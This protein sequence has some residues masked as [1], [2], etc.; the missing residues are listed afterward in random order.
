MVV[1]GRLGAFGE[2]L[3]G[4]TRSDH[5]QTSDEIRRGAAICR[6]LKSTASPQKAE[7]EKDE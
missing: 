4:G 5:P 6:R 2:A 3:T 7:Q 1:S